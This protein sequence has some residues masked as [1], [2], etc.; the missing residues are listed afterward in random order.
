M[1]TVKKMTENP[2]FFDVTNTGVI[3]HKTSG[4]STMSYLPKGCA[5]TEF[6]T[7]KKMTF[8]P[9]HRHFLPVV[10]ISAI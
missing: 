4:P 9:F 2:E 3:D 10:G 8:V 5:R 6:E 7:S 1:H